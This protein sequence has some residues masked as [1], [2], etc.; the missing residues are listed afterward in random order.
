VV[1]EALAPDGT[2]HRKRILSQ[3]RAKSTLKIAF[4][5]HTE[6]DPSATLIQRQQSGRGGSKK[7]EGF[8]QLLAEISGQ[9]RSGA[10]CGMQA[11]FNAGC[12]VEPTT[13]SHA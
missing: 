3:A 1:N 11:H 2:I 7:S 8:Y 13:D 12:R 6:A 5:G 10:Q 4:F 9:G